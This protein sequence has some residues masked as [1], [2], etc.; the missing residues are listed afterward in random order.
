VLKKKSKTSKIFNKKPSLE[1]GRKNNMNKPRYIET[2]KETF[3]G[4][5]VYDRVVSKNHFLKK[6]DEIIDWDHY[7]SIMISLYKGEGMS[8]RPPYD[9]VVL[10]KMEFMAY[11]YDLSERDVETYVNEN[12]PAKNFIGLAVDEKAPDHSTLTVFRDRLIKREKLDIFQDLLKDILTT[13]QENGVVFGKI[14]LIDSVH[15]IANV[16]PQ[17]DE[18]R[19]KKGE[20]ARDPDASWGVKQSKKIKTAEGK[21]EKVPNY[22]YGYKTHISMNAE[23]N[24]ITSVEVSTG[25]EYDGHHFCSLVEADMEKGVPAETYAADKGYDD[26]ENHYYLK[27]HGLNSAI[28]LKKTRTEKKDKNKQGWIQMKE[29]AEYKQGTKER[30]KIERKFGEAKQWHGFGRCRYI[31]E[32]KYAFQALLTAL[33]LNM[34]KIVKMITGVGFKNQLVNA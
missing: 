21:T 4:T 17:K 18:Q 30:Y 27:K 7:S 11:L 34:K 19:K 22:F 23:N 13:A 12:I 16:N 24:L 1:K 14:Q 9:P 29:K 31:G 26:G 5:Y 6:L 25:K 33:T 20:D 3:Y 32:M 28:N 2:G 15:T 8:G 10:L